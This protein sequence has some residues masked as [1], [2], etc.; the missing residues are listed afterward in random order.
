MDK[1]LAAIPEGAHWCLVSCKAREEARARAHLANQGISSFFPAISIEKVRNRKPVPVVEPLF[2]GYLFVR[3]DFAVHCLTTI[4][5]TRGVANFVRFGKDKLPSIIADDL[6]NKLMTD[7]EDD[8]LTD[9]LKE[10]IL[11]LPVKGE[12]V[13]IDEGPY[14]NLKAIYQCR[15]GLERSMLLIKMIGQEVLISIA[16]NSI[17]KDQ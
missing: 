12:K 5:S 15:D 6:V 14:Q 2:P 9:V 10:K 11:A 17:S 1:F 7:C 4:R 16:N 3:L 13:V 8:S